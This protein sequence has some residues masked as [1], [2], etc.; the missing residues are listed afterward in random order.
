MKQAQQKT[1][2]DYCKPHWY[3][4]YDDEGTCCK[5]KNGLCSCGQPCIYPEGKR[6]FDYTNLYDAVATKVKTNPPE[7]DI[8]PTIKLP[9]VSSNAR[10]WERSYR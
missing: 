6:K 1:T 4:I 9:H 7:Y 3:P 5:Y 2:P 10:W 8:M